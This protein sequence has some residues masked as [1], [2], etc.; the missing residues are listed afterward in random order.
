MFST[1]TFRDTEIAALKAIAKLCEEH[2]LAITWG[3]HGEMTASCFGR[4]IYVLAS[5]RPAR[6]CDGI[7][8]TV[9]SPVG[10]RMLDGQDYQFL[11]HECDGHVHLDVYLTAVQG[12]I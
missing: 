12:E 3:Q 5:I 10:N 7:H 8:L 9:R 4:R 1:D 2:D 6:E 11:H